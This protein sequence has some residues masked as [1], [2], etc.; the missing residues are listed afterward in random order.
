M[1]NFHRKNVLLGFSGGADSTAAVLLLRKA[2]YEVTGLHFNVLR[3]DSIVSKEEDNVNSVAKQLSLP[4]I[5]KD[6]SVAFK[7]KIIKSFCEDYINGRTPNPCVMCNPLIKFN[8]LQKTADEMGISYL[9]TG[10]YSRIYQKS[11]DI[12]YIQ[13]AINEKKDQSY[14]LYRLPE[15]I[16]RRIIFPLGEMKSKEAT[17]EMLREVGL[18]NADKKDSQDICFIKGCS[19]KDFI[20]NQGISSKP[21]NF[22]DKGG[23]ILGTHEG[24]VNYTIGQ[25]KGLNKTFGKP[26][27]VLSMCKDDNTVTLGESVDLLE[28]DVQFTNPCYTAYGNSLYLPSEYENIEVSVKLRYSAK[29]AKAL[30]TQRN[31]PY[32]VLKFEEPQRAPTSG[33]SAVLYI[34]DVLIGGGIII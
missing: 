16:V 13:Q 5:F 15:E 33:Q 31:A 21:G 2:G 32:P 19:Y 14:M 12:S 3:E 8:I 17:R 28:T 20:K 27:F 10:H 11:N 30:L 6:V 34:D 1:G 18:I 4:L 23:N 9:S 24:L 22:I 29:S 7:N 25:R 26:M